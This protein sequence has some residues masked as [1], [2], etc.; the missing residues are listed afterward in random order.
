MRAGYVR[1]TG[2]D[3]REVI[4]LVDKDAKYLL[5]SCENVYR[6]QGSPLEAGCRD[7][8]NVYLRVGD[9]VC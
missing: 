2:F 6:R 3:P 1:L 5:F 9:G 4:R 7:A 8:D